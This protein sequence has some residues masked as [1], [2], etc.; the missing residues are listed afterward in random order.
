LT[1]TMAIV[2]TSTVTLSAGGNTV[3]TAPASQGLCL[4]AG[5]TTPSIQGVLSYV[6]Q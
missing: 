5:G 2:T 6:Q 1:G 4:V 3:I